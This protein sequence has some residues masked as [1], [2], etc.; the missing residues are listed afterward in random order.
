M[1]V[2][3]YFGLWALV[4]WLQEDSLEIFVDDVVLL[5]IQSAHSA[6]LLQVFLVVT[7]YQLVSYLVSLIRVDVA[8]SWST[9]LQV[10][11]LAVATVEEFALIT[12]YVELQSKAAI[13]KLVD[14]VS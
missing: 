9:F 12:P 5:F 3:F 14:E 6:Y 2:L 1:L 10:T 8:R 13:L 4:N 11:F 7:F